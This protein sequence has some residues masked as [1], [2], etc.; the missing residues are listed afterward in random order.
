MDSVKGGA[1]GEG[2]V[3][4]GAEAVDVAGGSDVVVL[5]AGLFGGE[6]RPGPD[7][8][9]AL[10]EVGVSGVE[11]CQAEVDDAGGAVGVEEDVVGFE[12]AVEDAALVGV[13]DAEGGLRDQSGGVEGREGAAA[14]AL[15]EGAAFDQLGGEVGVAALEAGVEEAGDVGVVEAA[16]DVGFALEAAPRARVDLEQDLEG[17][18]LPAGGVERAVDDPEPASPQLVEE[19]VGTEGL[20]GNGN[21]PA[22]GGPVG[23]RSPEARAAAGVVGA[24][25]ADPTGRG[26]VGGGH[27]D[28][29]GAA[30]AAPEVSRRSRGAC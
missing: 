7:H 13:L 17:D 26:R 22:V 12:V 21:G 2:F 19:L 20:G 4:G 16:G 18:V 11:A 29:L 24:A 9:A 28:V 14:E 6:I 3:E 5:A 1:S 30:R 27:E 10:G 15:G 23:A 8:G 25:E